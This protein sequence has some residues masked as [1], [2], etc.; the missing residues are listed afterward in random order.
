[1]TDLSKYN[2]E[3]YDSDESLEDNSNGN[4]FQR[5]PSRFDDKFLKPLDEEIEIVDS[6]A[7]NMVD[8][9]NFTSA[10]IYNL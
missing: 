3:E 1:M 2:H 8:L 7:E 4:K 9:S 6:R 10:L 5:K